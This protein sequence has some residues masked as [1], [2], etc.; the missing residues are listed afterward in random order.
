MLKKLMVLVLIG[1]VLISGLS[2]CGDGDKKDEKKPYTVGFLN[3]SSATVG[4]LSILQ[5]AMTNLGYVEG[6]TIAYVVETPDVPE[7]IDQSAQ[8]LVDAKVD[9]IFAFGRVEAV[10]AQALTSDIPI[11][12]G[13]TY[14]PVGTGMVESIAHPG[15][16]MTGVM[17]PDTSQ[18]RLQLLLEAAPGTEN[19]LVPYNPA[20]PISTNML[21]QLQEIAPDLGAVI[22]PYEL[23]DLDAANALFDNLPDEVD[24]IFLGSDRLTFSAMTGWMEQS[25]VQKIPTSFGVGDMSLPLIFMGLGLDSLRG[26]AQPARLI[27]QIFKG[28]NPGDLPVETAEVSFAINLAVA[29]LMGIEVP[30]DVLAKANVIQRELP[31]SVT[32]GE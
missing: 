26:F 13:P 32:G 3:G 28:T 24:A 12:F 18:R 4:I 7:N 17:I 10:A 20:D 16:N 29:E 2:G 5:S 31:E 8:A 19:V 27:D 11:V 22:I 9:L 21:A 25:L 23:T 1:V 6:E 30:D 14:D 15:G